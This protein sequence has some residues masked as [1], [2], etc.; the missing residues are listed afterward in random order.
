MAEQ[1]H[2]ID[3]ALNK[4]TYRFALFHLGF[5]PFF[6][7]AM[8]F[9]VASMLIW[10]L[11]F[12]P[13]GSISLMA[14]SPRDWHAHEMMYGYAVA[15]IAGFLLTAIR[16]WTGIQTVHGVT[17][18]GLFLLWAAARLMPF[19]PLED[20]L[21][22]MAS[23]DLFFML[24]LLLAAVIPIA[25]VKQWNQLGI[26]GIVVLLLC[27]NLLFYLG[28]L[29][30][31]EQGVE[32]GLYTGLYVVLA[33][34]FIIGRRVI[35]FFIEKGIGGSVEVKNWRWLDVINMT[36]FILFA[37]LD[38]FTGYVVVV[39][40]LALLLFIIN[41]I[42]L[43]GW[44]APGLVGKPLLWVLYLAYMFIVAG[45]AMKVIGFV[46][47]LSASAHVHLFTVGGIGLMTTGM[48]AR[49]TLG[50]TGRN[51]FE[52]P[53]IL[54]AIFVMLLM[55]A[56]SRVFLPLLLPQQYL[57]WVQ[58]SQLLWLAAFL[59]LLWTYLPMLIKPRV[60]GRYG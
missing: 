1:L 10:L 27:G 54:L 7:G 35:P 16:N 37:I 11:L 19:I 56:F 55:S 2:S 50:H 29:N 18:F 45:F 9:A 36:L 33:L 42:R 13:V 23:L 6:L 39:A 15:V 25:K 53:K 20:N 22:L 8:V 34:I 31:L 48:M 52:P 40:G 46:Y 30:I 28:V 24:A 43:F 58:L 17:L 26:I 59:F 21:L 51:V 57:L 3:D 32:W 14:L 4:H 44:Y 38:V 5:R 41:S 60:D 12:V 49:V 47:G